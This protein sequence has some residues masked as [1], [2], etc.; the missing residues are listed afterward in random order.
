MTRLRQE[1]GVTL[2]ELVV[3]IVLL[4]IIFG[5]GA[6]ILRGSFPTYF[7]ERDI[8]AADGQAQL[9]LARMTREI[10]TIRSNASTD[11]SPGA[12]VLSFTNT[13]GTTIQ[14]QYNSGS[15][16]LERVENGGTAQTLADHVTS[17]TFSYWQ[18]DGKTPATSAANVYYVTAQFTVSRG[19]AISTYRATVWPRDLS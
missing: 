8:A 5:I 9:A 4:G 17:L 14:Y 2:I 1:T 6:M 13:A 18:S 7:A 3:V 16:T 15:Q 11:L 19:V 12:S 10:R